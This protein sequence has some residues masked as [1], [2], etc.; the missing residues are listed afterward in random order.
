[1]PT[2][3]GWSTEM[4]IELDNQSKGKRPTPWKPF[5]IYSHP[6]CDVRAALAQIEAEALAHGLLRRQG[7]SGVDVST[8]SDKRESTSPILAFAKLD[9]S[10]APANDAQAPGERASDADTARRNGRPLSAPGQP[11]LRRDLGSSAAGT[12]S[13]PTLRLV[14]KA[15]QSEQIPLEPNHLQ[16]IRESGISSEIARERG[17]RTVTTKSCLRKLGFGAQ[18]CNTP[19][20]LIP[21]YD[22]GGRPA[23]YQLRPDEPRNKEGKPVK[24]ETPH[25]MR[26][27]IDVHPSLSRRRIVEQLHPDD[28]AELPA[29]IADPTV[30]LLITEGVRKADSAISRGLCSI[31]LL[32][33]WNWRGKNEVGG[34]TALADWEHIALNGRE[35]FIVFDSDVMQKQQVCTALVR[36]KTFLESKKATVKVIY[37]PHGQHGE[38]VGL[39][40]WIAAR[41]REGKNDAHIRDEL[42]TLATDELRQPAENKRIADPGAIEAA[43]L[44]AE[45]TEADPRG[46]QF[47][48]S[49]GRLVYAVPVTG[50]L[51]LARSDGTGELIEPA[52]ETFPTRSTFTAAAL[53]RF[54]K[55]ETVGLSQVLDRVTGLL[56]SYM[57]FD[58]PWHAPL[59][60]LW[61]TGTYMHALFYYYGYLR[62][63]SKSKRC[64]KTRLLELLASLCFNATSVSTDPSG[65]VIYRECHK[66][67]STQIFDEMEW[68]R[69]NNREAAAAITALLNAGFKRGATVPR[70]LDPK[71]NTLVEFSVYSP[72][73][74]ASIRPLPDTT[75]DRTIPIELPRRKPAERVS[76]FDTRARIDAERLRDDLHIAALRNASE[77]ANFY[78]EAE[79][80][81]MPENIDDRLRDVLEPLLAIAAVADAQASQLKYTNVVEQAAR[82]L[83]G[84]RSE[85]DADESVVVTAALALKAQA[86]GKDELVVTTA[87]ARKIFQDGGLGWVD[88]DSKAR[89]LLRRLGYRSQSNRQ[90]NDF[91][92]GYK[93]NLG[94]LDEVLSRY[95]PSS[96]S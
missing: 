64:G 17:Y 63:R 75:E 96:P 39:D 84:L 7:A 24:Y 54:T 43:I 78:A 18:Q 36:L 30:P 71:T 29:L 26:M 61:I 14:K 23:R 8:G 4:K 21:L 34:L 88:T 69:S 46:A 16:L 89:A 41:V 47:I 37:L 79:Q 66:N 86:N 31:A 77:V 60:A 83:A 13:R 56:S 50:K 9:T 59:I 19:A 94:S 95:E 11:S 38:K 45:S 70:V 3:G 27:V 28:P 42:F 53:L 62:A 74:I 32:G 51:A 35:A 15:G 91:Q 12:T 1:M 93:I 55:G 80:L 49:Q 67:S 76:R 81:P 92:R 5:S 6:A 44:D 90:G 33:V 68:L 85:P 65:A 48:D 73:A 40:D 22:A 87:D 52:A 10:S 72:K 57:I 25:S 82:D 58:A 20:L 2:M